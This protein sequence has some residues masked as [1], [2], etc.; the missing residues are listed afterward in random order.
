MGSHALAF[1]AGAI[2]G[3]AFG[4]GGL[5]YLLSDREPLELDPF[6]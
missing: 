6:R 1:L 4:L 2:L 5:F 3:A